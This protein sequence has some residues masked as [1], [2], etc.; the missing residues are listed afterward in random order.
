MSSTGT[1]IVGA[2]FAAFGA[3]D[4]PGAMALLA[5]DVRWTLHANGIPW[6]GTYKGPEGVGDFFAKFGEFA[7]PI[8]M[9]PKSM[10]E[11]EG[12]VYVRGI[13]RSK[14]KASGKEYAVE[15][16]HVIGTGDGKITS[17]DEYLDSAAIAAAMR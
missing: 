9:T 16:V 13:E 3:G 14:V 1:A 6:G 11:A 7:E 5:P 15:W 17:F 2:F 12:L 4:V 8:E 10:V